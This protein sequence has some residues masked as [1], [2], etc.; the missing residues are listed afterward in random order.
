MLE[1]FNGVLILTTNSIDRF[2]DAFLSRFALVLQFDALDEAS[3]RTLWDRVSI[4]HPHDEYTADKLVQFLRMI[5]FTCQGN[6]LDVLAKRPLNGRDIKHA[7]QT[8]QA[9]AITEKE[10]LSISHLLEVLASAKSYM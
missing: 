7:I 6:D 4:W 1:Y 5:N 3:R 8:A 10:T 9:I 2:D